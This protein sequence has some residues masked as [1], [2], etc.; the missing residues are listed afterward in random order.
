[1]AETNINQGKFE[2]L[3]SHI[4]DMREFGRSPLFIIG[5]G[6]S[7]GKVPLMNEIFGY[8]KKVDDDTINEYADRLFIS[9][10]VDMPDY[11]YQNV[12]EC[13]YLFNLLQSP[14][15]KELWEKFTYDFLNGDIGEG[16]YGKLLKQE[17]NSF[18]KYIAKQIVNENPPAVCISLNYDGLT[19]K[20]VRE[21]ALGKIERGES[22]YPARVLSS[23][24][25]IDDYYTSNRNSPSTFFPIIKL[26]GDIFYAICRNPGCPNYNK[27]KPI[28]YHPQEERLPQC[29]CIENMDLELDFPGQLK[30]E[31]ETKRML[32]E[33]YRYLISSISCVIVCGV[34]GKWDKELVDFLRF[35][36]IKR[37]LRIYLIGLDKPKAIVDALG[38]Y[39]DD[40]NFIELDF[41]KDF[42]WPQGERK[43]D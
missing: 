43:S 29:E 15:K 41:S 36:A 25:E 19:A 11:D 28:Y 14:D 6:V 5:A 4:E 13:A 27:R 32:R 12:N 3:A 16:N 2:E 40:K 42:D 37:R 8:F 23:A 22:L 38:S 7:A 30:K 17:P 35:C 26:K 33:V 20:A 31:E 21:L 24:K 34:S 1:M 10:E 18:H 9:S 39:F